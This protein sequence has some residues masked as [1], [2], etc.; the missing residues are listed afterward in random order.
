[1]RIKRPRQRR[2]QRHGIRSSARWRRRRSLTSGRQRSKRE[3]ES[4]THFF[5]LPSILLLCLT[6]SFSFSSSFRFI[7]YRRKGTKQHRDKLI[8][9]SSRPL[10][11]DP[12]LPEGEELEKTILIG[13]APPRTV[14]KKK[15][16]PK[17]TKAGGKRAGGRGSRG[18]ARAGNR[19]GGERGT[20]GP[21]GRATRSVRR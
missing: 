18:G 21:L 13:R 6:S 4:S 12:E 17:A 19:R 3:S 8:A 10:W 1:M 5:L 14:A 9:N 2:R 16:R 20:P 7:S 15:K 11:E